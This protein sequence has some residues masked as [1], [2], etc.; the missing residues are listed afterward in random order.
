M[1]DSSKYGCNVLLLAPY[2]PEVHDVF[3]AVCSIVYYVDVLLAFGHIVT[4][5]YNIIT[6]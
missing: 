2:R 5:Y 6:Y 4:V 3:E 1:I